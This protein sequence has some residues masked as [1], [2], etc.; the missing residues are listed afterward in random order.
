MSYFATKNVLF[1]HRFP[2]LFLLPRF[3]ISAKNIGSDYFEQ[4]LLVFQDDLFSWSQFSVPPYRERMCFPTRYRGSNDSWMNF[5]LI[6]VQGH[7]RFLPS[8]YSK[9]IGW[10]QTSFREK[11]KS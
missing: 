10:F 3:I 4:F 1:R 6:K 7:Q 5:V 2:V 9:N 11:V 8:V